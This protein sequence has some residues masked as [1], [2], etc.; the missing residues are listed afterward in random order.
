MSTVT[1]TSGMRVIEGGKHLLGKIISM[2]SGMRAL[3][4]GCED[5][6]FTRFP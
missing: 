1:H 4:L 2:G 6:P 3:R 5:L